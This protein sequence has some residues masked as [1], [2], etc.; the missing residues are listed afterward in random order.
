MYKKLLKFRLLCLLVPCIFC[1]DGVFAQKTNNKVLNEIL[2]MSPGILSYS[3]VYG[4]TILYTLQDT[5]YD[6]FLLFKT[7]EVKFIPYLLNLSNKVF[8][9][10]VSFNRME[11]KQPVE[12][13]YS[14]FEKNA[15]FQNCIFSNNVYFISNSFNAFTDFSGASFKDTSSF[16]NLSFAGNVTFENSN[17]HSFTK[18]RNVQFRNIAD[19]QRAMFKKDL[20]FSYS[21]FN[22][23]SLFDKAVMPSSIDLS[24]VKIKTELDFSTLN[25]S[26]MSRSTK[27]KL[28]GAETKNF[29]LNYSFFVLD[30]TD[31]LSYEQEDNIYQGMLNRFKDLG[32]SK[33]YEKLDIEYKSRKAFREN[34]FLSAMQFKL[35]GILWKHGYRKWLVLVWSGITFFFFVFFNSI[36]IRHVLKAHPINQHSKKDENSN[37]SQTKLIS[38]SKPTF[39]ALRTSFFFTYNLFFG[40]KFDISEFPSDNFFWDAY[41]FFIYLVGLIFMAFILNYIIAL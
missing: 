13:N 30:L 32:Y 31:S 25:Y 36:F 19:F 34:N 40:L 22:G 35:S 15:I 9:G 23:L 28:Y 10:A 38:L 4:D 37:K 1:F 20:V 11:F 6:D 5:I 8:K 26:K 12:V 29:L 27:I 2:Q 18:F 16:E 41:V 17:F 14:V 7:E 21:E 33:S 24:Y 39:K 3:V